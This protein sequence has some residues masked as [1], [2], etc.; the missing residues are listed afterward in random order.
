MQTNCR[1]KIVRRDQL[2]DQEWTADNNKIDLKEIQCH[3]LPVFM[4]CVYFT[5]GKVVGFIYFPHPSRPVLGPIQ[6]KGGK[7]AGAWP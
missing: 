2:I 1:R 5:F 3:T 4:F 7:A 6:P